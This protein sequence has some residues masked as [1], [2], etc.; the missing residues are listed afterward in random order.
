MKIRAAKQP[1][2]NRIDLLMMPGRTA[3]GARTVVT[4]MTVEAVEDGHFVHPSCSMELTDAQ[5][6]MDSL[7]ECGI[8][9]SEGSGSAGAMSATQKHLEDMRRLVFEKGTP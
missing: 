8:R 7:W 1:W 9:P 5:V 2:S 6:L 4:S 3:D